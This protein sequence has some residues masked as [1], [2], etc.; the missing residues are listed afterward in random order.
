MAHCFRQSFLPDEL[1]KLVIHFAGADFYLAWTSNVIARGLSVTGDFRQLRAIGCGSVLSW[2]VYDL[3]QIHQEKS[4]KLQSLIQFEFDFLGSV[5]L[6]FIKIRSLW[7][8]LSVHLGSPF[9]QPVAAEW[10]G[11]FRQLRQQLLQAIANDLIRVLT[12][13]NLEFQRLQ[14][15]IRD[16]HSCSLDLAKPLR[17]PMSNW[18][19]LDDD[20]ENMLWRLKQEP[21]RAIFLPIAK[22]SLS[23]PEVRRRVGKVLQEHHFRYLTGQGVD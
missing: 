15:V 4:A 3:K 6:R 5:R 8:V 14:T 17:V 19:D 11:Y 9:G 2:V 20:L 23:E 10:I 18:E 16:Q 22:N 21:K 13:S 7:S 12:I 1:M